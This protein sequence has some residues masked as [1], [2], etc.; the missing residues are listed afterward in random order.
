M[1]TDPHSSAT[2]PTEPPSGLAA[3]AAHW[4][5]EHRKLAIWGWIAFVVIAVMAGNA[6]GKEEIHG[7]DMF[8]GESHDAEETLYDAG[9]RPNDELV[10]I[11]SDSLTFRDPEFEAAIEQTVEELSRGAV[12]SERHVAAGRGGIGVRGRSHRPRRLRDHRRRSRGPRSA[13]AGRETRSPRSRPT[14]PTC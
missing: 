11:Q 6:I 1:S 4:S 13:R 5:A 2:P 8:N 12:R 7:A 9:M 10:I 14:T 3:R